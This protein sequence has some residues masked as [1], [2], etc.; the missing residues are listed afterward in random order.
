MTAEE[1]QVEL[2]VYNYLKVI[3]PPSEFLEAYTTWRA[4]VKCATGVSCRIRPELE[5][6]LLLVSVQI[7]NWP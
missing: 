1:K 5:E 2:T 6:L 3:Y 7:E 4:F